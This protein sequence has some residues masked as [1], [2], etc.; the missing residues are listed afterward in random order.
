MK[1]KD[2]I[3]EVHELQRVCFEASDCA[4]CIYT[5]KCNTFMKAREGSHPLAPCKWSYEDIKKLEANYDRE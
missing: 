5:R 1:N 2:F 4:V 3:A